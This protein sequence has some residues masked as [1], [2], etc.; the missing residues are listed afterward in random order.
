MA[1][2]LEGRTALVT[3]SCGEGMGRS[4]ALRLARE[5]AN[6]VLN[7]GTARRTKAQAKQAAGRAERVTAAVGELGGRAIVQPADTR[8]EEQV[9]AMVRAGEKEFGAVDILVANAGGDWKTRDYT[10]VPL[11]E[12][13]AV[14]QAEI[15]GAFLAMKH[16]APGM[17]KRKWGRIVLL[18]MSQSL[19]MTLN[20][21]VAPDYCL[22]KAARA[23]M[24][25]ALWAGE[26]KHGVT[27]NC[28]EPG[29]IEHAS[30]EEA[31]AAA[32]E[33]PAREAAR[34][35]DVAEVVAF[36]CSEAGRFVTGSLIRC[37]AL[38]G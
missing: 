11:D 28:V 30:M 13:R 9:R 31:V 35:C 29:H 18:G 36:L 27:V 24:A 19:H 8:D 21:W 22:G 16:C 7:Y 1:M 26:F 2:A 15:D 4:I 14:V 10:G 38:P 34:P 6:L 23:W 25:E 12:W 33:L 20:P 5:G 32:R 17:R 37:G 3:G